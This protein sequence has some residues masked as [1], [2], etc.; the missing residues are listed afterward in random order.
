MTWPSSVG[1]QTTIRLNGVTYRVARNPQTG[2]PLWQRARMPATP[3]DL[4]P[5][6]ET[7]S[8]GY[9]GLGGSDPSLRGC[10]DYALDVDVESWDVLS[11][12]PL[13]QQVGLTLTAPVVAMASVRSTANQ[14]STYASP[15]GTDEGTS[16][17]NPG[18]IAASD[19]L[20]A[21]ATSGASPSSWLRATNWGISGVLSLAGIQVDV[22]GK[23][24]TTNQ[25][26]PLE[27]Q[28]VDGNGTPV[29]TTKT[30]T[31]TN[32]EAY[33]SAGGPSDLWGTSLTPADLQRAAFGVRARVGA[34]PGN[35]YASS[36]VNAGNWSNPSNALGAAN[37]NYAA[38]DVPPGQ[39]TSALWL[40]YAFPSGSYSGN[41]TVT[42]WLWIDSGIS[43]T[44]YIYLYEGG[45]QKASTSANITGSGVITQYTFNF[46]NVSFANIANLQVGLQFVN[47]YTSTIS[48][49]VDAVQVQ[50]GA[51]S[52]GVALNHVRLLVTTGT[53]A[54][55]LYAGGG[56]QLA[57]LSMAPAP[58]L[59]DL[60]TFT[61][62]EP[63]QAV[64][65]TDIV[66]VKDGADPYG[67]AP[68][69]IAGPFVL[70]AFGQSA[71][72]QQINAIPATGADTYGTLSGTKAFASAFAT[73]ISPDN[74]QVLVWRSA[75]AGSG[76]TSFSK[77]KQVA[78]S[79]TAV[80]LTNDSSWTPTGG[81]QMA[82]LAESIT[83]LVE[84]ARGLVVGKPSGVYTVDDR[85]S[86]FLLF[87][88]RAYRHEDNCRNLLPW[89]TK[90]LIPTTQDLAAIP[91]GNDPFIGLSRLV[92]NRSPVR[93]YPTALACFGRYLYCAFYDGTNS[94]ICKGRLS[95][96][97][98]PWPVI[99]HSLFQVPNY[100]V[101]ALHVSDD[102]QN[103]PVRLF[104]SAPGAGST[105]DVGYLVLDPRGTTPQY[106]SGGVLYTQ[107]FGVLTKRSVVRR[108]HAFGSGCSAQSYWTIEIRFD[109]G[110][111]QLVGR[112]QQD[113]P[114]ALD[115][116]GGA[117]G[118]V[119]QLRL[120]CT[121][122]TSTARPLLLG[123][124]S[125]QQGPGGVVVEGY[126]QAD[127][128]ERFQVQ[129]VAAREGG[130]SGAARAT[131]TPAAVLA[132]LEAL[133]GRPVS[134]VAEGLFGDRTARTVVV[135]H[136]EEAPTAQGG[137]L[138]AERTI[139]VRGY[140]LG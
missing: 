114:V 74:T 95:Q 122:A 1:R 80:D 78:L 33:L 30:L 6:R 86:P 66:A 109:N 99:W 103:G 39:T 108:I 69:G 7:V 82:D 3:D 107:R 140:V 88:T 117:S 132:D 127:E 28:L 123:T 57:K 102:G 118:F 54:R 11:P 8:F 32:T 29:G 44:A 9:L 115:I 43:V 137:Q 136:V 35:L 22:Q 20:Y 13:R 65:V 87:G 89:G 46:T 92:A 19:T 100:K 104:Y 96:G 105:H 72:I 112:V 10:H 126:R 14:T 52:V 68:A 67:I 81:Y 27:L 90:L 25:T 17:T 124:A 16:W 60:K 49:F 64:R 34:T 121:L 70:I 71:Q 38:E 84:Y 40:G 26:A 53:N 98:V 2:A 59:T 128:V 41:V 47:N 75:P 106:Q 129:I 62:A 56:A 23:T 83:D 134:L 138:P 97:E 55:L 51:S 61:H 119:G 130:T 133:L 24:T 125:E 42:A 5:F 48:V 116:P 50:A 58:A 79:T 135:Q 36:V 85:F 4:I 31:L 21:T 120:T 63:N 45:T 18:N 93:G 91:G 131:R 12:G 37:G 94:W 113:G 111:W 73:T 110:P 76:A 77:I 15:T 101:T 139:V